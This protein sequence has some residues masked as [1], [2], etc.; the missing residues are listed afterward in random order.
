M[1]T[2]QKGFTLIELM[3]VIAIIGILAAIAIPAYQDYIA[4]A[5]MSEAFQLASGQKSAVVESYANYGAWPAN[6]TSA[7]AG[8]ASTIH[9]KYVDNVEIVNGVITAEMRSIGVSSAISGKFVRL[10]PVENNGSY[11]WHCT[12]DADKNYL[13]ASCR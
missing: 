7:G 13:V 12:S 6:N 4:R 5:Q 1:K 10:S 2:K 9:G 11:V 8:V 3:I